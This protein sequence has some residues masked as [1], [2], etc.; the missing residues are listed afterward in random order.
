MFLGDVAGS[1]AAGA[2]TEELAGGA[3]GRRVASRAAPASATENA[4]SWTFRNFTTLAADTG[5][6]W[7]LAGNNTIA[8]VLDN[9]DLTIAPGASLTV[10]SAV[11]RNSTGVFKLS[12]G[13]TLDL[14]AGNRDQYQDGFP[15][16]R[17][18]AG[19][20]RIRVVRHRCRQLL[21]CERRQL[22]HFA[23]GD[24]IDLLPFSAAG[25]WPPYDPSTE[26]L[27]ISNSASQ[28]ASLSF[29]KLFTAPGFLDTILLLSGRP[30]DVGTRLSGI[31][32]T[33]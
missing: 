22:Q 6:D 31:T 17:Q 14:A 11:D 2:S 20:Q 18:P 33:A 5:S 32:G 28:L 24:V 23:S 9:G 26:R 25:A 19:R 13:S 8:N 15:R 27:Q 4:H 29:Q 3:C 10:T 1:T 12:A 21:L 7:T 30:H 16:Q